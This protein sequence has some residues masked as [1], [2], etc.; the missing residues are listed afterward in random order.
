LTNFA[1]YSFY[2][3]PPFLEGD[4]RLPRRLSADRAI[5]VDWEWLISDGQ[6]LR[7]G[8]GGLGFA[9]S[10]KNKPGGHFQT[11]MSGQW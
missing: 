4:A 5:L 8:F 9:G 10:I 6:E 1:G 2:V 11:L 3:V 7:F